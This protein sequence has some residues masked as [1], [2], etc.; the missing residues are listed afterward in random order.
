MNLGKLVKSTNTARNSRNKG[1]EPTS[2]TFKYYTKNNF[3]VAKA[4][5]PSSSSGSKYSVN[6]IFKKV[7]YLTEKKPGFNLVINDKVSKSKYF[8]QKPTD[9]T[10]VAVR[11]SCPDHRFMWH[12][13]NADNKSLVGPRIPY[14]RKAGST[15]PPKNP[16][17][18]PGF[19]K[20]IISTMLKLQ[21]MNL[22]TP[23]SSTMS[24]MRRSNR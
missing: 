22:V 12:W 8:I 23:S 13:Y 18:L 24:T 9:L 2:V 20:H 17:Q 3:L 6:V 4:V 5:V 21:K 10:E 14:V 15:R 1:K 11:C 19:C 7:K 16:D